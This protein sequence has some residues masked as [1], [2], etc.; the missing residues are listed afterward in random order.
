MA[1]DPD[2]MREIFLKMYAQP[3]QSK[4]DLNVD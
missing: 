2:E 1:G 3:Y 4:L